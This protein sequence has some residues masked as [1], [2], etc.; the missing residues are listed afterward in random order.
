MQM[1]PDLAIVIRATRENDVTTHHSTSARIPRSSAPD[2][3]RI[4]HSVV[5]AVNERGTDSPDGGELNSRPSTSQSLTVM[6]DR[7]RHGGGEVTSEDGE[8][9]AREKEHPQLS[10][11]QLASRIF[12]GRDSDPTSVDDQ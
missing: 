7:E 6:R 4:A 12:L 10:I 5:Q 2:L 3:T 9:T 8:E 1:R 11:A